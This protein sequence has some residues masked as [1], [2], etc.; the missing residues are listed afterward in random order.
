MSVLGFTKNVDEFEKFM[1]NV[2]A[3][4]GG[5][6]A[7]DMAGGFEKV[8]LQHWS[9]KATKVGII[10]CDAPCHGR[11]FQPNLNASDDYPNGDPEGRDI[12]KQIE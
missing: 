10:I 9:P 3:S 7:E 4:G 12:E 2:R 6:A 8:L 5:D 1:V 11:K